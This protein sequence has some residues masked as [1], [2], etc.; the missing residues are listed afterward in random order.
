MVN[1][2][3]AAFEVQLHALCGHKLISDYWVWRGRDGQLLS[4]QGCEPWPGSMRVQFLTQTAILLCRL[5]SGV[6]RCWETSCSESELV[7]LE[8]PCDGNLSRSAT[9][10][11]FRW[12]SSDGTK[13]EELDL[14]KHEWLDGFLDEAEGEDEVVDVVSMS[15]I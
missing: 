4:D 1:L 5:F 13:P 15:S 12:A 6:R 9:Q 8:L 2:G 10:N 11:M 3:T 14:W 7:S